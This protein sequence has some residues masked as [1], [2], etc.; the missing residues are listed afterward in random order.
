MQMLRIEFLKERGICM[1]AT[2]KSNKIEK[3]NKEV[4]FLNNQIDENVS[5]EYKSEDYANQT[6]KSEGKN[7]G[8]K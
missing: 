3:T 8:S 4:E 7:K 1:D 5:E 6:I 2:N